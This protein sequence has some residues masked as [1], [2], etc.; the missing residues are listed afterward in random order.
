MQIGRS[1]GAACGLPAGRRGNTD[2]AHA[3]PGSIPEAGGTGGAPP[4]QTRAGTPAALRP[5]VPA[6]V[7]AVLAVL[8]S[9]LAVAC[10]EPAPARDATVGVPWDVHFPTTDAATSD[11]GPADAATGSADAEADAPPDDVAA[12]AGPPADGAPTADA[13]DTPAGA[14]DTSTTSCAPGAR[15]CAGVKTRER[16]DATGQWREAAPCALSTACHPPTGAC[17]PVV[18]E[19]QTTSCASSFATRRCLPTGTGWEPAEACPDGLGC[20]DGTCIDPSCLARAL[21]LVDASSSMAAH[22]DAVQASIA[23][24]AAAN[25]KVTFGLL[26]FP[27]SAACGVTVL[28]AVPIDTK[29]P[30]A[31]PTWFAAHAP[32]GQTPLVDAL[33]ATEQAAVALFGPVGGSLVVLSDGADTCAWPL[34]P[35]PVDREAKVTAA[36]AAS[37]AMLRDAHGVQTWVI[38]YAYQGSTGQLDAIAQ[39]GGTATGAWVPAGSEQELTLALGSIVADLK[40][41]LR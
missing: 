14:L 23:A 32:Y 28:P 15:R 1:M 39:S 12:D 27:A 25:P 24:V 10:T 34:E 31:V 17:S 8:A 2:G 35:D 7:L 5:R 37:A 9:A 22:W 41:C 4:P 6:A 33:A 19:P 26:P 20:Q 38:G 18:C 30:A 36:L 11:A 16:C 40:G 21:L 13:S 3:G 29:D